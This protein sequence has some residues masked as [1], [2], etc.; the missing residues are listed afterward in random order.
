MNDFKIIA[1]KELLN[2]MLKAT[3]VL[4][5]VLSLTVASFAQVLV[6]EVIAYDSYGNPLEVKDADNVSTS[7]IWDESGVRI[8]GVA[9]NAAHTEVQIL[10]MS[11][12][13]PNIYGDLV[14]GAYLYHNGDGT[15]T[16][17]EGSDQG[18][19]HQKVEIVGLTERGAGFMVSVG[20]QPVGKQFMV[21]F[22][23]NIENGAL[24]LTGL[25][26]STDSWVNW[27]NSSVTSGWERASVLLTISTNGNLYFRAPFG[28]GGHTNTSFNF[29][30]IRIYPKEAQVRS[31]NYERIFQQPSVIYDASLSA[32]YFAY[33]SFGRLKESYNA[34]GV[35]IL[36]NEYYYSLQGNSNYNPMD[37]NRVESWTYY[38]AGDTSKVI[39]SV[40]YL[41]GLGRGIQS[42]VRGGN[43][44]I[45]TGTKYNER[46]LPEAVSRPIELSNQATFVPDLFEGTGTFAPEGLGLGNNS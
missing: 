18:I 23:Y 2:F 3:G 46:G 38:D 6:Q 1:M 30:H 40:S 13:E 14:S 4:I 24:Q 11:N 36:K 27:F 25:N 33:D 20:S 19:S 26:S 10:N 12:F 7:Y 9:T 39:K 44:T 22:E 37:P 16:Y 34:H 45:V 5:L 29:R 28:G 35:R 43:K 31:A 32:N 17:S 15:V 41:D 21:E 42:Q 8:K